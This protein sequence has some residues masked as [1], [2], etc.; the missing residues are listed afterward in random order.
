MYWARKKNLR[1]HLLEAFVLLCSLLSP[2]SL[3]IHFSLDV[4]ILQTPQVL[5]PVS[6][7]NYCI[8]LVPFIAQVLKSTVYI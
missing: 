5:D 8:S 2:T 1:L 4:C 7:S 3:T 6:F